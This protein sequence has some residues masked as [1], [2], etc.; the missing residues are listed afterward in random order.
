MAKKLTPK[1]KEILRLIA[2]VT[3]TLVFLGFGLWYW[4]PVLSKGTNVIVKSSVCAASD[5]WFRFAFVNITLNALCA[6]VAAY[7]IMHAII[8]LSHWVFSSIEEKNSFWCKAAKVLLSIIL[9]ALSAFLIYVF[10]SVLLKTTTGG[11]ARFLV[12]FFGGI[13]GILITLPI[14]DFAVEREYYKAMIIIGI[15]LLG[16]FVI[17]FLF[18]SAMWI[19]SVMPFFGFILLPLPLAALAYFS[20]EEVYIIINGEPFIIRIWE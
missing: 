1:T 8:L 9:F 7:G 15:F 20:Y 11:F 17:F 3:V 5:G 2:W 4:I 19:L 12:I 13:G 6:F 10:V 16:I 14:M 18:G